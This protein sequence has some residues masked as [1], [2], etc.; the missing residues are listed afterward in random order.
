MPV[1]ADQVEYL[2]RIYLESGLSDEAL[3]RLKVDQQ[4][5]PI[6]ED[7]TTVITRLTK[8]VAECV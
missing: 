8:K 7:D 2:G 5:A 1:N 6:A 4:L 3:Q